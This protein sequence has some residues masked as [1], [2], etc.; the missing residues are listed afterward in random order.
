MF[1]SFTEGQIYCAY[2][3]GG[4]AAQLK[5]NTGKFDYNQSL[6]KQVNYGHYRRGLGP[7]KEKKIKVEFLLSF[8]FKNKDNI[9]GIKLR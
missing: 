2:L 1:Y 6:N 9:S 8:Q 4:K 3:F 7:H 5:S